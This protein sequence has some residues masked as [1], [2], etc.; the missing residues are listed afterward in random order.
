MNLRELIKH[1]RRTLEDLRTKST[2]LH[3]ITSLP[4]NARQALP[5]LIDGPLAGSYSLAIVN[6]ELAKAI[7]SLGDNTGLDISPTEDRSPQPSD[8][9]DTAWSLYRRG[10]QIRRT[11]HILLRTTYP[12]VTRLMTGC[13]N[14][15]HSYAWEESEFIQSAVEDFNNN[16]TLVTTNSDFT[17]RVLTANGVLVP[18]ATTGLGIDH[19]GPRIDPE[20]TTSPE[21]EK[22]P[23]TFLHI[24][25]GF[26][27]KGIDI[28]LRAYAR[29]FSDSDNVLLV[30]KTFPNPHNNVQ[31]LL[32]E[33]PDLKGRCAPIKLIVE[34]WADARRLNALY[35]GSDVLVAPSRGEGFGMPLAESLWNG[36]PVIATGHGGHLDFLGDDYPWL[37][38]Y[39]FR[40]SH[41]HVSDNVSYW[42]EPSCDHLTQLLRGAFM[43]SKSE[44]DQLARDRQIALTGK[45]T[46]KNVA[47]KLRK[48]ISRS[49]EDSKRLA[50]LRAQANGASVTTWGSQCGIAEYA[51][52]LYNNAFLRRLTILADESTGETTD[53]FCV[54]RLWQRCQSVD[55]LAE[56]L[57][58]SDYDFVIVQYH[59]GFFSTLDLQRLMRCC[60]RAH[61]FIIPHNVREFVADLGSHD[62]RDSAALTLLVHTISDLNLIKTYHPTLLPRTMQLPHGIPP[63]SLNSFR[64]SPHWSGEGT[65]RIGSFGF[66][67]PHKGTFHLIDAA[68]ILAREGHNIHLS[69]Y[70]AL[71]GEGSQAYHKL[72]NQRIQELGINSLVTWHLEFTPKDQLL[73]QLSQVDI[74]CFPYEQH[75]TESASGAVRLAVSSGT[76][77]AVSPSPIFDELPAHVPVF[78]GYTGVDIAAKLRHFLLAPWDLDAARQAQAHWAESVS[79]DRMADRLES[80]IVSQ[81]SESSNA[82]A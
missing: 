30:L 22:R 15:Y 23:F 52:Y 66:L 19:I 50:C 32:D 35:A 41:S 28:L 61:F 76:P 81:L 63:I 80:I 78:D 72:C 6:R 68:H 24:S 46:W 75:T 14:I 53:D 10:Q 73:S 49:D 36:R 71:L 18:L 4:V 29:A 65:F 58:A 82:P 1:H 67:L 55:R 47:L 20:E 56:H 42:A 12:P 25:S 34:D 64:R 26:P 77:V 13:V 51:A 44:R 43:S 21:S 57:R 38:D 40:R 33:L 31:H 59:G 11:P 16:L 60:P 79:F 37:I 54:L 69:L 74:L 3:L 5:I 27:R 45:Y 70:M 17:R 48:V 2:S 8:M 9:D 62:V 7:S 39:E